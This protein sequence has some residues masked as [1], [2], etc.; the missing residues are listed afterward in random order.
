MREK[1]TE[2]QIKS[3]NEYFNIIVRDSI[4]Q[5]KC[6]NKVL[7]NISEN[8]CIE[9]IRTI[10]VDYTEFCPSYSIVKDALTAYCKECPCATHWFFETEAVCMS[11]I[12]SDQRSSTFIAHILDIYKLHQ[13][14]TKK[15][16]RRHHSRKYF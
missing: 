15:E 16:E 1:Y 8:E 4:H 14:T 6:G 5:V 3:G 2:K 11:S 7:R 10:F 13:T 9:H 12:E